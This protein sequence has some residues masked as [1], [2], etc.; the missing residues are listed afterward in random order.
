MGL[1]CSDSIKT[2][3]SEMISIKLEYLSGIVTFLITIKAIW[4]ALSKSTDNPKA[5]RTT[6]YFI[7]VFNYLFNTILT[8]FF[9]LISFT[10]LIVSRAL[11]M[12]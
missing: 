3:F 4:T 2:F 6:I 11:A 1:V 10:H 12:I 9:L 5:F 7:K 8:K